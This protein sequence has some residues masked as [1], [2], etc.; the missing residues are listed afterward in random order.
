MLVQAKSSED[1]TSITA[2]RR[3]PAARRRSP[4]RPGSTSSNITTRAYHR[5]R[6]R[7][8]DR[9]LDRRPGRA[10]ASWSRASEA[11][12]LDMIVGQ[13]R[14]LGHGERRRRRERPGHHQDD[15]GV[16]RRRR[17]PSGAL[18]LGN[19]INAENGQFAI[20]YRP[21]A[22]RAGGGP[23][24]VDERQPDGLGQQ[25]DQP[26]A[27]RASGSPRRRPSRSTGW[28]SRRSTRTTSRGSA[29]TAASRAASP[30]T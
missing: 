2:R 6:P 28:R 1:I 14:R 21:T 10:A 29:S 12:T 16:H 17:A 8:P 15:R 23:A 13:L 11:T 18:G 20:T 26:A 4:A 5:Q 7:E 24:A 3:R 22:R 30:S 9:R 27:D 19:A 25:P